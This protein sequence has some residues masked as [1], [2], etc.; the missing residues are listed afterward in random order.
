[1][2]EDN[3]DAAVAVC[4]GV[5]GDNGGLISDDDDGDAGDAVPLPLFGVGTLDADDDDENIGDLTN[6]QL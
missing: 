5:N 3:D 6:Y 1:V 2:A 4:V